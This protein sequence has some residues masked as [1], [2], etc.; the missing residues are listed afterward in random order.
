[1]SDPHSAVG[2]LATRAYGAEGFWLSTAHAAKFCEVMEQAIEAVPELPAGL[3]KAMGQQKK[4]TPFSADAS[5]LTENIKKELET[6]FES[7]DKIYSADSDS[8]EHTQRPL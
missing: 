4:F 3:A 6:G 7:R 5:D 1:M 2:Y 8:C